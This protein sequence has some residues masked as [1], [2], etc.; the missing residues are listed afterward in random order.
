MR[1][2]TSVRAILAVGTGVWMS[3]C[4]DEAE[5][6]WFVGRLGED[7]VFVERITRD[8]STI[9]GEIVDR[10]PETT[11]I[12]FSGTLDVN[13]HIV[14]MSAARYPVA[15]GPTGDAAS[16]WTLE[17]DGTQALLTVVGGEF[18]GRASTRRPAGDGTHHGPH[19]HRRGQLGPDHAAARR[20]PE[21]GRTKSS[22]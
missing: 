16:S 10:Q 12:G 1:K 8:G 4:G 6:R 7:T 14:S 9:E 5:T 2:G 21:P 15:G 17:I 3:G 13:G 19:P 22:S 11:R 18:A 20:R